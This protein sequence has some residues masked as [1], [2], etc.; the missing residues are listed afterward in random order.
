MYIVN[1]LAPNIF[2]F[3]LLLNVAQHLSFATLASFACLP[4]P[5]PDVVPL[6]L[7][8]RMI[9]DLSQYIPAEHATD[10]FDI[11]EQAGAALTGSFVR[12][13]LLTGNEGDKAF[14][15]GVRDLNIV[16]ERYQYETIASALR[17]YDY[18]QTQESV[19]RH[20]KNV[21]YSYTQPGGTQIISSLLE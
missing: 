18:D 11:L 20:Y 2:L 6:E 19:G 15:S 12:R 9:V 7:R 21:A 10:F 16:V 4:H 5:A 17:K 13:L 8:R 1:P 14:K 3:E